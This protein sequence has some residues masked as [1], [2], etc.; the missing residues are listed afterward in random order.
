MGDRLGTPRNVDVTFLYI[1]NINLV[2]YYLIIII[3]F[4]LVK[5]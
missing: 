2:S 1:F 5:E 4:L 3:Y